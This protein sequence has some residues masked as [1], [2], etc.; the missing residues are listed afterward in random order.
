MNDKRSIDNLDNLI[1]TKAVLVGQH[2]SKQTAHNL[3]ISKALK[4]YYQ[5]PEGIEERELRSER[6]KKYWASPEGQA[7]KERLR[8]KLRKS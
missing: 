8:K 4:E 7:K 2:D 1:K 3:A 5:T 6:T